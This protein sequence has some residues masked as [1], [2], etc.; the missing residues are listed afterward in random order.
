MPRGTNIKAFVD[1]KLFKK[2]EY[3]PI[4]GEFPVQCISVNLII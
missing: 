3:L 4:K 1:G 2:E